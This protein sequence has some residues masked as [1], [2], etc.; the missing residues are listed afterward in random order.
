MGPLEDLKLTKSIAD[1][2]VQ[3]IVNEKYFFS[4]YNFNFSE[5][6]VVPMIRRLVY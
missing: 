1:E 6:R 4:S 2:E 3:V 5:L